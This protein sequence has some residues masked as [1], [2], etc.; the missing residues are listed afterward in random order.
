MSGPDID[1]YND[2]KTEIFAS[3]AHLCE[4]M[5]QTLVLYRAFLEKHPCVGCPETMTLDNEFTIVLKHDKK[6]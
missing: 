3:Q 5:A 4:Y 2:N 6:A 1:E